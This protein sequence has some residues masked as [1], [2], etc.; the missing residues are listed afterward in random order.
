MSCDRKTSEIRSSIIYKFYRFFYL[1]T[2]KKNF[3][4]TVNDLL[5]WK[6]LLKIHK[7]L[8]HKYLQKKAILKFV[9]ALGAVLKVL[10]ILQFLIIFV[11]FFLSAKPSHILTCR[12]NHQTKA[13]LF[14]LLLITAMLRA[15]TH[16][17]T[18]HHSKIEQN[19]PN[20]N[21]LYRCEWYSDVLHSRCRFVCP[22][23]FFSSSVFYW[24]YSND[25]TSAFR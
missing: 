8:Q 12:T 11:F 25:D 4:L 2:L 22:H 6:W 17:V 13:M 16:D 19:I 7:I 20:S 14:A 24:Q 15:V 1:P 18:A 3:S 21:C 10:L 5:E 9:R 23:R